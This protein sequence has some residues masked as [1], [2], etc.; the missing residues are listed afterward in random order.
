MSDTP[1]NEFHVPQDRV[2][3]QG[4]PIVV[5]R[6]AD[7]ND[8]RP[9]ADLEV[10]GRNDAL[11]MEGAMSRGYETPLQES[12]DKLRTEL[13]AK[14]PKAFTDVVI[15]GGQTLSILNRMKDYDKYINTEEYKTQA[16]QIS[17]EVY[18]EN[19]IT[20]LPDQDYI[21]KMVKYSISGKGE[22]GSFYTILSPKGLWYFQPDKRRFSSAVRSDQG[23][24]SETFTSLGNELTDRRFKQDLNESY[25]R[26]QESSLQDLSKVDFAMFSISARI[27]SGYAEY[28]ESQQPRNLVE[29]F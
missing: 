10:P 19:D 20:F 18:R 5:H 26:T 6:I 13:V 29:M 25:Q 23:N 8:A 27:V 9:I 2:D 12:N 14:Y 16:L 3:P 28:V 15:D 22:K 24:S 21:A 17:R 11:A 7:P 1:D 4:H